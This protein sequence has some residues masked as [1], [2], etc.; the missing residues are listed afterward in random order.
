M[1]IDI[2]TISVEMD[3][4][5]LRAGQSQLDRTAAAG[6]NLAR[7]FAGVAA[8][9]GAG[10]GVTELAR[11]LVDTERV[12]GSLMASLEVATGSAKNAESA[13][14]SLAQLG[15]E[16]PESLN[17]VTKAFTMMVNLGLD[18]SQAAM[19]SYSNTASAMNKS[20]MQMVE[21][22]ADATTGQYERLKEFG[23]KASTQGDKVAFTF[24]GTTTTV[25]NS[26]DEITKYLKAIGENEFAGMAE[27]KMATL[28][29]AISN[30]SDSWDG[31]F[32]TINKQGSGAAM[33]E[34]VRS[35]TKSIQDFDA[36]IAS[37]QVEGYIEAIK[38][39][40]RGLAG[41]IETSTKIIGDLFGD[42]GKSVGI[43]KDDV[44]SAFTE[45]PQNIRAFIQIV[46]VELLSLSEK[47]V[48]VGNL[49]RDALNPM[50]VYN[51]EALGNFRKDMERIN[52][53]RDDSIAAILKEKEATSEAAADQ[54]K[55]ADFARTM[56]EFNAQNAK[57]NAENLGHNKVEA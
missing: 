22:V 33:T 54:R 50:K 27:K 37:S 17:D 41:D 26:A 1:A 42:I 55:W 35:M 7:S 51:G 45:M 28:D 32:R 56:Y 57:E 20:L 13:F 43:T 52:G 47:A 21:A 34:L 29:G 10:L 16:L 36:A 15:S 39:Q 9:F 24:R 49:M 25:K 19:K 44:V 14:A 38:I 2:T 3:T 40:F 30:L 5:S 18:P 12:T 11:K 53:V 6:A 48:A 4:S 8:A 31:L 46:V 23:I